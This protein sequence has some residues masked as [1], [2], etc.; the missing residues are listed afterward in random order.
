MLRYT[1]KLKDN[2]DIAGLRVKVLQ[3]LRIQDKHLK[4]FSIARL[5]IDARHKDD[6]RFVYSVNLTLTDEQA[7]MAHY[8]G[9]DVAPVKPVVYNDPIISIGTFKPHKRPVIIGF[10]PAG[11][12]CA[13]K[14]AVAGFKPLVIERGSC[15][16]KRTIEVENFWNTGKLNESC[17]VLFG[18]GGAGTFSDGK[19]NTMINDKFGRITEVFDVF[20]ENG[21][22]SSIKYINKPHIG[23]DR[24]VCMVRSIREKILSLGGEIRFDTKMEEILFS[25][26]NC[27]RGVRLDTGEVIPCDDL[28]LAIGHSARDTFKMLKDAKVPLER[29]AFACGVRVEHPQELIGRSQY[30]EA[31]DKLPPADYKVTYTSNAGRG[32][33]SFCMCPGGYVVNSSSEKGHL[34]VNGMS[35]SDRGSDTANSAIIVQV[36]PEDFGSEDV[37]AGVEFQRRLERAAYE[38]G[39]GL[40][41]AQYY[42]DFVLNRAT[43]SFDA[44]KPLTKGAVKP[45][46]LNT[47]LPDFISDSIKEAFPSFDR[48]IHGFASPDTILLGVETRTSSPLRIL[49][50]DDLESVTIAGLYPAGEGAGYAGGI[51]S[52]A[53]DGLKVYEKIVTKY[54]GMDS[55]DS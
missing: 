45:C 44:Q 49:R 1:I 39:T 32:V 10:G 9:K 6:I 34:V 46:D 14:L 54:K 23:T 13:Y 5:S 11:M 22:D 52:A 2:I 41:P 42:E 48:M 30:G 47:V 19:L 15:T 26:S 29:K 38:T 3:K 17:N 31:F 16:E 27:V 53:I 33:Y 20:V 24:L 12:M 25:D 7:F 18:E 51:T 40:I 8:R 35:Y 28:V 43:S 55:N 50:N 21:A 4:D 36:N 37:L